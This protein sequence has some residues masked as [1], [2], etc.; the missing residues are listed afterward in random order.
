MEYIGEWM[1]HDMAE[2]GSTNDEVKKLSEN[3]IGEKVIIS[4]QR[5]ISGRGRRGHSWIG[6]DGNLFFS[7]GL[8]CDLS[9]IG[10]MVFISTLSLWRTIQNLNSMLD[11]KL[12]WPNDIL[13]NDKKVSG[14][15]LEKGEGDYLIIG[16]GVNLKIAPKLVN[17]PYPCT[18][19][20]EEGIEV[21]RM[22]FLRNYIENFNF[23][24]DVWQLQ[25]FEPIREEWQSHVKGLHEE[26][27]VHM[28]N[29]DF[30]GLFEGVNEE[31]SL[32]LNTGTELKKI[33]AGDVFYP[34]RKQVVNE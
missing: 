18:S 27:V 10:A 16:I 14:M 20:A 29:E 22:D 25:G 4:A 28:E 5:Q 32:L 26:I 3:I 33:Y 6:L 21:E 12:K 34:Q 2:V 24:Y 7:Q 31:G 15:L 11:V 17:M 9:A 8:E 23:Y 1:L 13:V 30:I 19:L